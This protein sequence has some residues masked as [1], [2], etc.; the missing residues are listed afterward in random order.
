MHPLCCSLSHSSSADESTPSY[1]PVEEEEEEADVAIETELEPETY[2]ESAAAVES[3]PPQPSPAKSFADIVKRLA[4][5]KASVPVPAAPVK[6]R[7]TAGR[8]ERTRS[9]EPAEGVSPTGG[10]SKAAPVPVALYVSQLPE[11]A[12]R[13]DLVQVNKLTSPYVM[14]CLRSFS[15][16]QYIIM[17]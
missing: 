17:A 7:S 13:D 2:E 1:E 5:D 15:C 16:V 4:G 11:D 8:K 3:S 10:Q 12:A 6:S 9:D 14:P